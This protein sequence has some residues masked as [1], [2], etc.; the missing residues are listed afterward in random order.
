[1]RRSI[2]SLAAVVVLAVLALGTVNGSMTRQPF[3]CRQRT[4]G[5]GACCVPSVSSAR[6][7]QS[8][9]IPAAP[10]AY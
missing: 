6:H 7:G 3:A 4:R 2:R 5:R 10:L 1:M 9:V 8:E